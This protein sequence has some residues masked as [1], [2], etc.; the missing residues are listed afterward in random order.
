MRSDLITQYRRDKRITLVD[1][2]RIQVHREYVAVDYAIQGDAAILMKHW[3]LLA[4]NRLSETSYRILAVVHDEIQGECLEE[5]VLKARKTLK[6]SAARAGEQL[7]FR[8]AIEADA[9]SGLSWA[10]TH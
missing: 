8:V 5:D 4:D 2:R 1:G 9:T 10:E 3:A 7:G 6:R